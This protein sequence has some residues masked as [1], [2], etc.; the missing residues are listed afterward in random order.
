[1]ERTGD[2]KDENVPEEVSLA[3]K[4]SREENSWGYFAPL[5]TQRIKCWKLIQTRKEDDNLP[6]H[7]KLIHFISYVLELEGGELCLTTSDKISTNKYNRLRINRHCASQ[8][9]GRGLMLLKGQQPPGV[10]FLRTAGRSQESNPKLSSPFQVSAS[11]YLQTSHSARH[12]SEPQI[13]RLESALS[14]MKPR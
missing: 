4:S 6:R 2:E 8:V 5:K 14:T 1:M 7:R 3:K 12:P 11:I 10:R 13:K 9:S